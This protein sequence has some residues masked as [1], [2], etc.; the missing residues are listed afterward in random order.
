MV[1]ILSRCFSSLLN[2]VV[3]KIVIEAKLKFPYTSLF[4]TNTHTHT[5]D[6]IKE[7]LN[8]GSYITKPSSRV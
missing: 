1:S 6:Y 3:F 7:I 8:W 2:V 5:V 4:N